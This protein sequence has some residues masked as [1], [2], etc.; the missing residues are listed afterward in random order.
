MSS[1]TLLARSDLARSDGSVEFTEK[2]PVLV[3]FD[4]VAE[5]ATD[6]R[7]A[8][9]SRRFRRRSCSSVGISAVRSFGAKRGAVKFSASCRVS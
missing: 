8:R 3:K 2:E 4:D 1:A 7:W 9:A 5:L 6:D